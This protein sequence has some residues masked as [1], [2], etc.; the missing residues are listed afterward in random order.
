VLERDLYSKK[1]SLFKYWILNDP[2]SDI[3]VTKCLIAS[4]R[5]AKLAS[6][7]VIIGTIK[8]MLRIESIVVRIV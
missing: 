8:A 4:F 7:V 6:I 1:V 3:L 2:E 5:F